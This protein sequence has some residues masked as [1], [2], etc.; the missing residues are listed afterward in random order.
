MILKYNMRGG[1]CSTGQLRTLPLLL[2]VFV[3]LLTLTYAITVTPRLPAHELY[4][5]ACYG[6]QPISLIFGEGQLRKSIIANVSL[7]LF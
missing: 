6:A 4:Q 5:L 1:A 2:R 3:L 7:A